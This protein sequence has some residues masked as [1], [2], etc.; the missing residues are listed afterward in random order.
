[1]V[2]HIL[3]KEWPSLKKIIIIYTI[4]GVKTINQFLFEYF[5]G[6]VGIL[7]KE[8]LSSFWKKNYKEYNENGRE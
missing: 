4:K 3:G 7:D 5:H 8:V 1:M 6:T 2:C